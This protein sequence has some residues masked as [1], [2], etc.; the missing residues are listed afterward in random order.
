M[1]ARILLISSVLLLTSCGG[2]GGSSAAGSGSNDGSDA[3]SPDPS[4]GAL[5]LAGQAEVWSDQ[6]NWTLSASVDGPNSTGVSFQL[7]VDNSGLEIDSTTGLI[8][9]AATPPG[10]YELEI[11][12]EDGTGGSTSES[13]SFTSNAFI[14]G[15]W[16][17]DLPSSNE[18]LLMIISRNGRASITKSS[19]LGEVNTVCHGP[20]TI[21]GDTISGALDCVDAELNRFSPTVAGTVIEDS[22]ITLTDFAF[23]DGQFLFQ[24]QAEVFNF[25]AIAPGI[26]VE[27]SDI[28][29]GISL[30]EVTADGT[31]ASITP[32]EVG[33]QNKNSRCALS[34]SLEADVVFADYEFES[35][36]N[37]LQVFEANITLTDCDLGSAVLD[38]LDYNQVQASVLGASV[39]DTLAD[40]LSFNLYFPGNDSS[41]ES[42]NAGY[43]RYVQ[44]CDGAD[45]LTAIAA[46]LK[47]EAEQFSIIACPVEEG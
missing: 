46:L 16:L 25:G 1:I 36:K 31:L 15:H 24:T 10:V 14:A 40:A 9:G 47:D 17:M 28:A 11:T 23:G 4:F 43:F 13:F 41:N 39:L 19:A 5:S 18:Q 8:Q 12:A 29:S 33:F 32:A 35:L 27:Y 20:L 7:A 6:I 37:A 22:S 45:Q 21:L 44:F 3:G 42:Q 34:G 26:Y 38:S 30:V 2:G